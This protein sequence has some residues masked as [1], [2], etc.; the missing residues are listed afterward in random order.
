MKLKYD[1]ALDWIGYANCFQTNIQMVPE[2]IIY[3]HAP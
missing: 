3:S 2:L 1:C